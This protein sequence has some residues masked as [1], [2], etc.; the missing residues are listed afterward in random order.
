MSLA[1]L[2]HAEVG[3]PPMH[4]EAP[5]FSTAHATEVDNTFDATVQGHEAAARAGDLDALSHYLD[6]LVFRANSVTEA[7][8]QRATAFLSEWLEERRRNPRG[9]ESEYF[10]QR[11]EEALQ[12]LR[13]AAEAGPFDGH[14]FL[15]RHGLDSPDALPGMYG[16]WQWAEQAAQGAFGDPDPDLIFQL[17]IRGGEVP[18]EWEYA[19]ATLYPKWKA[20]EPFTFDLCDYVMSGM[21]VGF[22][23]RRRELEQD[24]ELRELLA[25]IALTLPAGDSDLPIAVYEAAIAFFRL[26]ATYEEGHAGADIWRARHREASVMRHRGRF[27]EWIEAR[28]DLGLPANPTDIDQLDAGIQVILDK[29]PGAIEADVYWPEYYG[30]TWEGIQEAQEAWHEMRRLTLRLLRAMGGREFAGQWQAELYAERL[31]N[32]QSTLSIATGQGY[33]K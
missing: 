16:V 11:Y 22:C 4:H 7:D 17:V 12:H 15:A 24:R 14:A 8:P 10:W 1:H 26:K 31:K 6:A 29:L 5:L 25:R 19:V 27:M 30:I 21:G 3:E 18:G 9:N 20:G 32:L 28:T 33:I 2:G 13:M 23:N